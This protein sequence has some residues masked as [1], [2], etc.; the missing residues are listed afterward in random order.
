MRGGRFI[1]Y[2]DLAQANGAKWQKVRRA[3]NYTQRRVAISTADALGQDRCR[4][5]TSAL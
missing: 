4:Q 2:G 3:M 5:M 1:G